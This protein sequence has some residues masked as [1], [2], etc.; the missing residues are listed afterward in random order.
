MNK[1]HMLY[2]PQLYQLNRMVTTVAC[3]SRQTLLTDI[4]LTTLLINYLEK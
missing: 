3:T 2:I 4:Y 1:W